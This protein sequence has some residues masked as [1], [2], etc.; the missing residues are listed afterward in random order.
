MINRVK[1]AMIIIVIPVLAIALLATT[2][3]L[4]SVVT[5]LVGGGW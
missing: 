1:T 5:A 2:T 4:A 3:A